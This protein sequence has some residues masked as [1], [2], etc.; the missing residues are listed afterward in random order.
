VSGCRLRP[1]LIVMTDL[2]VA[3]L[4]VLEERITRVVVGAAPGSVMVQLRDR[5]LP[6]RE[7]IELGKRLAG[8]ARE[9]DQLFAVNDRVDLAL[10]LNA[11]GVHLGEK[12]VVPADARKLLGP[13]KY[14]SRAC[15][16]PVA[17]DARGADALLLSPVLAER[18]GN[19]P[20]GLAAIEKARGVAQ[21]ALVYALG[22]VDAQGAAQ[23]VEAGFDGVAVIGA[24]LSAPSPLEIL[25]ALGIE[26][27]G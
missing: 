24:V 25:S 18:K 16:D 12:S 1:R 5:E 7:R 2:G 14:I 21:D 8:I 9:H 15:H 19:P 17:A 3:P 27:A 23:C 26:R 13:E 11:D 10:I 22:G 4:G 20:L 6:V